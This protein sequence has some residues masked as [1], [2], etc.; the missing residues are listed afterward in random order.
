MKIEELEKN[1]KDNI[2]TT[3]NYPELEIY[4]L[5]HDL[6][7]PE[8]KYLSSENEVRDDIKKE[9]ENNISSFFIKYKDELNGALL[10]QEDL[11]KDKRGIYRIKEDKQFA[12]FKTIIAKLKSDNK[13]KLE[14]ADKIK[15]YLFKFINRNKSLY[16]FSKVHEISMYNIKK[17]IIYA[18]EDNY[19]KKFN[20]KLVRIETHVD[21]I[22]FEENILTDKI[23]Y[24]EKDFCYENHEKKIDNSMMSE[25]K[26]RQLIEYDDKNLAYWISKHPKYIKKLL[27]IKNS[28]IFKM[29]KDDLIKRI[30]ED[31]FYKKEISIQDKKI[32]IKYETKFKSFLTM[33]NDERVYSSF[34]STT[35]LSDDKYVQGN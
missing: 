3:P 5:L 12:P 2:F 31:T 35:Y 32:I 27:A 17:N 18:E 1:I 23:K 10:E 16:V 13:L 24:L 26:K 14:E 7:N 15:G 19:F 22:F 34:S 20:K 11:V 29:N 25:W 8:T 33:M 30:S 21:I 6:S 28:V 9:I 4:V